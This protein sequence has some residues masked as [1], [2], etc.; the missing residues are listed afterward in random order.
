MLSET[1][2]KKLNKKCLNQIKS[3]VFFDIPAG[4]NNVFFKVPNGTQL[5]HSASTSVVK[6]RF[7]ESFIYCLLGGLVNPSVVTKACYLG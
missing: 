5:N 2:R 1:E 3:R 7:F 6:N 4:L